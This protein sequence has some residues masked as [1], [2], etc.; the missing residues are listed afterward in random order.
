[1][2]LMRRILIVGSGGAGKSTMAVEVGERLGLPVVHL[3]S[4]FWSEGWI[5][6]PKDAWAEAVAEQV[7]RDAW[8][9]DGNFNGTLD[10]R[11]AAADTV[12]FLDL[13][14]TLC[15]AR[16]LKRRVMYRGRT[17][18]D[19]AS[20]CPERL[21]MDFLKWVWN[22]PRDNRPRM[23]ERLQAAKPDQRI[24]LLKTRKQVRNFLDTLTP[25]PF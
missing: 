24:I 16:L 13:P 7:Q 20:G 11:L 19:M 8:V 5:E 12:I 21:D 1:M 2:D 22:Y 9:I 6:T 3:D 23:L 17:R 4:L 25:Q 18:P 14:R 15:V 10:Q